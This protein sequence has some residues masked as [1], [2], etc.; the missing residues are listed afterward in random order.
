L[1][2]VVGAIPDYRWN[3]C[4]D[5]RQLL[6]T[7]LGQPRLPRFRAFGPAHSGLARLYRRVRL[8]RSF[9]HTP[10]ILVFTGDAGKHLSPHAAP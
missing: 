7:E 5:R 6:A 1:V 10:Q 9:E 8:G 3:R 4:A 2:G